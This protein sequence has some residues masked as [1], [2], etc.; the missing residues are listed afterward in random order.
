MSV[1]AGGRERGGNGIGLTA[2]I[3]ME[4]ALMFTTLKVGDK[5]RLKS[6]GGPGRGIAVVSEL[7]ADGRYIMLLWT[8]AKGNKMHSSCAYH[9]LELVTDGS[10]PRQ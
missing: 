5:V 4:D 7:I 10:V 6:S 3:Q 8:D 2:L 1:V 9:E